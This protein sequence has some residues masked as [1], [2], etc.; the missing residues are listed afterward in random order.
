M[1][2]M[3]TGL[4][5]VVLSKLRRDPKVAPQAQ[6]PIH[7]Y[8]LLSPARE[9]GVPWHRGYRRVGMPECRAKFI[10]A[11]LECAFRNRSVISVFCHEDR[12]F[13]D[14]QSGQMAAQNFK[15]IKAYGTGKEWRVTF[16]LNDRI[17]FVDGDVDIE[18]G[19][20]APM[21][22]VASAAPCGAAIRM[23]FMPESGYGVECYDLWATARLALI[24]R[25]YFDFARTY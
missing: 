9:A 23:T 18:M 14:I 5:S 11:F 13:P 25:E 19:K 21:L 20:D 15:D 17:W 8:G 12:T 10:A 6:A 4:V 22:R 7:G 3:F 1:F 24:R 16:S 2:R